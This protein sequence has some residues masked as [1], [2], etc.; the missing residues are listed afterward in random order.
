MPSLA[1]DPTEPGEPAYAW[2]DRERAS[3]LGVAR[4]VVDALA[5]PFLVV[6]LAMRDDGS[7]VVIECNDG[8]EAGFA[9]CSPLAVWNRLLDAG[10]RAARA[11]S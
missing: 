10:S 1:R 9:G 8:Q 5:V 7:W 4:C 6:D 3:G 2:T 11:P